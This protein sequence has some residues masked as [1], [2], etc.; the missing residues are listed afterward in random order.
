MIASA[1]MSA[2]IRMKTAVYARPQTEA[3]LDRLLEPR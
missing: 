1:T 3:R 2:T